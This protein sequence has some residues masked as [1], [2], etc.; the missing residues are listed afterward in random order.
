M[1]T[2]F[3]QIKLPLPILILIF[4]TLGIAQGQDSIRI[5]HHDKVFIGDSAFISKHDTVI[6][7]S[8]SIRI[9]KRRAARFYYDYMFVSR[10]EKRFFE[11]SNS[12]FCCENK[13]VGSI[14]IRKFEPFGTSIIDT[15]KKLEV[16]LNRAGNA[17]H[18]ITRDK[19]ILK[20]L[21][22]KKGD[23]LGENTLRE[24]ERLL[25]S[26]PYIDDAR[27]YGKNRS[28]IDTVDIE[29]L[30]KDVFSIYVELQPAAFYQIQFSIEESN[31]FGIGHRFYNN[32][33][34]STRK[35]FGYEGKYTVPSLFGTYA[36][37]SLLG[38]YTED[39][40]L[41]GLSADRPFVSPEIRNAGGFSY[42]YMVYRYYSR[43]GSE[44]DRTD[45]ADHNID[46]WYGRSFKVPSLKKP[47][48]GDFFTVL[49]GR[50]SN[51]IFTERPV[52]SADTNLFFQSNTLI[53]ANIG[54]TRSV[55][56]KDI[57]VAG[58]G[59]TEDL[60]LGN[61]IDVTAGWQFGEFVDRA[62]ADIQISYGSR[63]PRVGYFYNFFEIGSFFRNSVPEDGA[64][65]LSS[66]YI[67]KLV[68][69]NHLFK[70]RLRF[71][72]LYISGINRTR[73]TEK[74]DLIDM[75]TLRGA[76][77]V[78]LSGNSAFGS[79][80]TF[81]VFSPWTLFGF[82]VAFFSLID[83]TY[84][85]EKEESVFSSRPYWGISNGFRLNNED[86]IF[87]TI[88]F[89]ISFYP[90]SPRGT[91]EFSIGLDVNPNFTFPD[92]GSKKPS[93]ISY[94]HPNKLYY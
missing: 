47:L 1:R 58:F 79:N 40:I 24:S 9:K 71:Q 80:L 91:N 35:R 32:F 89:R 23:V 12:E 33:I 31:M 72:L 4:C 10:Q 17:V 59:S 77:S 27:I 52:A 92:F 44:R 42:H 69:G 13:V 78:L 81:T 36:Q 6:P 64:L 34:G 82:R 11:E 84:F 57:L 51:T 43:F 41:A 66:T 76:E 86:F 54:F 62:Y 46:L 65:R 90:S 25:R 73:D 50:I 26:L 14:T 16:W 94:G 38:A 29:V 55:F 19:A 74:I 45:V 63:V 49:S 39:S 56:T 18:V 21:L 28:T 87:G 75:Q 93:I 7:Y 83:L 67:S 22:F 5:K 8:D 85:S 60:P 68:A 37:G 15:S 88:D 30:V 70:G 3:S 48:Y 2:D 20:N 61:L 53:L